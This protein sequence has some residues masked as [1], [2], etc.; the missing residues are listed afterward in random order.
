MGA[1]L[2]ILFI[3][4]QETCIFHFYL[5]AGVKCSSHWKG[6]V[7]KLR[8]LVG[9]KSTKLEVSHF[10]YQAKYV[11]F[12]DVFQMGWPAH[13]EANKIEYLSFFGVA[14]FYPGSEILR[15]PT[16]EANSHRFLISISYNLICVGKAFKFRTKKYFKRKRCNSLY[17]S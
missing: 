15:K 9:L 12:P 17:F 6:S 11:S 5:T 1:L 13:T 7:T 14:Y 8:W 10:L 4:F 3:I 16:P 2:G